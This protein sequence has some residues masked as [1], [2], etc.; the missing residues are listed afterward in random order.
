[1][2]FPP[3][4]VQVYKLFNNPTPHISEG[5]YVNDHFF[6]FLHFNHVFELIAAQGGQERRVFARD[7]R[8]LIHLARIS[9]TLGPLKAGLQS[10]Y[11]LDEFVVVKA[12]IAAPLLCG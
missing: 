5:N 3:T 1:M 6:F 4:H 10:H 12:Q 11:N 7:W 8:F 9:S 2:V